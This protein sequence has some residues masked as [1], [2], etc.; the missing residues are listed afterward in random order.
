MYSGGLETWKLKKVAQAVAMSPALQM[1]AA[2]PETCYEAVRKALEADTEKA[3][4]GTYVHRYT[5]Q[6]D[7]GELEWEY[8]PEAARPFVE[9]Y[10]RLKALFEW[11]ALEAEATIY[12][13][14]IGYAGSAD[15]FAKFPGLPARLGL[16]APD[17]D[18]FAVDVKTGEQ[19]WAETA[20]Q[21]AAYANGEGI[22]VAPS[23]MDLGFTV[24]EARLEDDIRSGVGYDRI[25][26]NRRKWSDDAIREARAAVDA[27]WWDAYAQHGKF[28]PMPAGLRKDVGLVIHLRADGVKLIPLRLDGNPLQRVVPA[29]HVIDGLA[30]L[31]SWGRRKDVIGEAIDVDTFEAPAEGTDNV[32]HGTTEDKP[33]PKLCASCGE[34]DDFHGPGCPVV[35]APAVPETETDAVDALERGG[36]LEG[37]EIGAG[38]DG[39]LATDEDKRAY[40]E[41]LGDMARNRKHLLPAL[42]ASLDREGLTKKLRQDTWTIGELRR[43]SQCAITVERSAL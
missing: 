11:V 15:R 9:H 7:A 8:V 10:E 43:W 23:K 28:R 25:N 19:V 1:A 33:A 42:R 6:I 34:L 13:L 32:E 18:V 22:F 26:P 29:M 12:N 31:Y 3:D 35:A 5:E 2:D 16:P 4:V 21:L 20:L 38:E 39:L 37:A 36:L 24:R 41:W 17:L 14:L 40:I 27:E 30:A